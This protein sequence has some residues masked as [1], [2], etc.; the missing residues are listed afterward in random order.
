METPAWQAAGCDTNL[1]IEALLFCPPNDASLS[2]SSQYSANAID[3]PICT[4]LGFANVPNRIDL[5]E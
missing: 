1:N 4:C 3:R 5:A 2:D